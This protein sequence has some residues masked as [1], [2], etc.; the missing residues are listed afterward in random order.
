MPTGPKKSRWGRRVFFGLLTFLFL[1]LVGLYLVL[2]SP[3]FMHWAIGRLN[4]IIPGQIVYDDLRFYFRQGELTAHN[5]RYLN[6]QNEPTVTVGEMKLDFYWLAVLAGKLEIKNL[7][8]QDLKIDLGKFHKGKGPSQWRRV[9]QIISKRLSVEKSLIT[10]LQFVL[11]NGNTLTLEEVR[12]ELTRQLL[13]QQQIHLEVAHTELDRE[14]NKITAGPLNFSGSIEI[15]VLQEFVFWV[16]KAKGSLKI[17]DINM[18]NLSDA[19]LQTQF[20]IDGDN[21][22]LKEGEFKNPQGALKIDLE[23]N[24][25]EQ[26]AFKIKL[27]NDESIP[28]AAL[29]H[30]SKNLTATFDSFLLDLKADMKGKTLKE[31]SGAVELDLEAKGV[32]GKESFPDAHLKL[33]GKMNKGI[34]NL[35]DFEITADKT[36]VKATGAVD[37][38]RQNFDAKINTTDFN[39][40]ELVNA[41]AELDLRGM[42]DA[43]GTV[44]GPFKR[45]NFNLKAT[46]RETGYSFLAFDQVQGLFKIEN[47]NL[48]FEG[49]NSQNGESKQ[50][51]VLVQDIYHKDRKTTLTSEFRN[52]DAGKLLV[53]ENYKGQVT[54]TFNMEASGGKESGKLQAKVDNFELYGFQF[55]SIDATGELTDNRFTLNPVHFKPIKYDTLT[56]PEPTV[57]AFDDRGWTVKGTMLP[58]LGLEGQF[59]K[60]QPSKVELKVALKNT[61]LRPIL[62]AWGLPVQESYTDGKIDMH[63]GIGQTPS[64]IEFLLTRFELP[65]EGGDSLKNEGNIEVSLRPPRVEFK[66][67][68]FVQGDSRFQIAG[69]YV[70]EGASSLLF[71]GELALETLPLIAPRLLRS[72]EGKAKMNIKFGGSIDHPQPTGDLTFENA[73][74]TLRPVRAN[75]ENLNGT[76]RFTPTSMIFDRLRGTMREGDLTVNGNVALK[77]FKP[78]FY[79]LKIE[80]REVA[81]SEPGVYKI[82]FSGDFILKGPAGAAL[83]SGIMDINDGVYS[84]D[85]SLAQTFLRP[86]T[87]TLK[88]PPPEF[89]KDLI[90]DLQVRSPG[91]L[92]IHNNIARL[93]FRSDLRLTGPATQPKIGGALTILDG[94]F[95]YFTVDFQGATG[96]IDFRDPTRGPYANIELRKNYASSF[97]DV[98]VLVRIEGFSDNLQLSLSSSPPLDRSDLMALIFTGVLP[99]DARRNLSGPNVATTVLASQLSQI[100]QRPLERTTH[101]DIFRLEA[102]D[103]GQTRAFSRLVIGKQITDRFSLEYKTDL[104][105]DQPLQGVQMEYLLTD[106]ILLKAAQFNDGSFDLSLALR[107]QLF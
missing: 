100:I 59:L 78:S 30:A 73:S 57:F 92:A 52:L 5:L 11:K 69:T 104:G 94:Q 12:L 63:L 82:I 8:I 80:T 53:N 43:E 13:S 55:E 23:L 40:T 56:M 24:T 44:T 66:N 105:V 10:P 81:I 61:D 68:R 47:G 101:L 74:L 48:S 75:V 86:E 87:P 106:R 107:F 70:M 1:A 27:K 17:V 65:L 19:S 6:E 45:P 88:E 36:K 46:A 15:P 31:L 76:I 37:F 35:G 103:P 33:K 18:P 79:D 41:L 102:T 14:N 77:D 89:L 29:P 3:R 62:A 32:K 38:A 64:D 85:F 51:K 21:V 58:G 93:F 97:A 39:V 95:H 54:G 7:N 2:S 50:V 99:G 22:I 98:V 84:R 72:G 83:L 49:S 34:L 96:T 71:T 9:L 60:S 42:A 4:H 67:A 26:T 91:E 90:L 20:A 25:K 16:A 28:F